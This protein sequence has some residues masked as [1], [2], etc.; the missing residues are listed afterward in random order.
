MKAFRKITCALALVTVFAL[1]AMTG[2]APAAPANAPANSQPTTA[3]TAAPAAEA[4]KAPKY[5]FMFIGDG[6]GFSQISTA[7]ILAKK[8]PTKVLDRQNL[9]FTSFQ[10]TGSINTFDAESFCPDSASTG[11]AMATGIKPWAAWSG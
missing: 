8:L 11:T 9:S 2:C 4:A 10:S 6:M 3:P 1:L 7:E 5:V